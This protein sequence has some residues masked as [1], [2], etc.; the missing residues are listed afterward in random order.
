MSTMMP[1]RNSTEGEPRPEAAD[2][3]GWSRLVESV[4]E[5]GQYA[6]RHEAER[7]T[8]I[9]LSLLGAQVTGDERVALA[10]R[11]PEEAAR[12]VAA[13]IPVAQ[14]LTAPRFV[15]MVAARVEGA[16]SATARWDV[17]SVLG[18]LPPV[19][20]NGLTSRL[21]AA[22]PHGYALLFGRADLR[23]RT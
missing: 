23:R 17:S 8:R 6:T 16:T 4:R 1:E 12:L 7:V 15:D 10:G 5:S 19:I 13:Q 9:V 2:H 3:G 14:P 20:G 21:L 22:L 18:S 11:L